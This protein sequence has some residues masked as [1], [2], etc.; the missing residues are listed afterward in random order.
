M[1]FNLEIKAT[2]TK[3]LGIN[4]EHL[5]EAKDIAREIYESGEV[6]LDECDVSDIKISEVDDG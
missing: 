4:A 1:I 6:T 3:Q 2:L 5:Q